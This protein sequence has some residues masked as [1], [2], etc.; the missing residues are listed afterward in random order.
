MRR[1]AAAAAFAA[2]CSAQTAAEQKEYEEWH[3]AASM[4]G[5]TWEPLKVH[6]EDGY[7]LTMMKITG[8]S[9]KETLPT[10]KHPIMVV[11]PMG[12][13]PHSWVMNYVLNS[14][15]TLANPVFFNL[16]DQGHPL[17][18]LYVRGLTYSQ[19][20]DSYSALDEAFWNFSWQD[21]GMYDVPAAMQVIENE[22]SKTV[23]LLGFS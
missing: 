3:A 12:S 4:Y 10:D 11:P 7:T 13:T 23:G 1:Y 2:V 9:L 5:Y 19:E 6:T 17:Y 16:Y 8:N 14:H 18:L 20:N 22:T 21:I 15:P